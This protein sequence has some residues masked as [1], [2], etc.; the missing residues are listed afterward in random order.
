MP[1]Y[2]SHLVCPVSS[3]PVPYGIVETDPQGTI[4]KI[5]ETGGRLREEAGLEFYPGLLVPGFVNAHCHLELSHLQTHIP[6]GSGLVPFIK[7]ISSDR[8]SAE[9]VILAAAAQADRVMFLSGISGVGDISNTR[10]TLGI[11][12]KS[13]ML[14][15]TFAEV[16]GLSPAVA[17]ERFRLGREIAVR[18]RQEGLPATLSPHAPYSL[19]SSLWD[20]ISADPEMAT[21][22]SIHHD[23]SLD[24]RELLEYG[25]GPMAD[26]FREMG[27][28]P[29][30]IPAEASS[31]TR[32]LDAYLP[33]AVCLAVH[34]TISPREK[35]HEIAL[36]GGSSAGQ[37][38]PAI[39]PVLC[40]LSNLYL[41]NT[42]PDIK[43]M[44]ELGMPVCLGTDSLASNPGLSILEEMKAIATRYPEIPFS[45]LLEWATLN[46][47]RALGFQQQLGS[48]EPG[49][50]PGVIHIS[51]YDW[52]SGGLRLDSRA[53]RLI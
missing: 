12:K 9:G 43:A 17:A 40:P 44:A 42:L 25:N 20:L 35:L 38:T 10:I 52:E 11:K 4:L 28:D 33:R 46:G 3:P 18:F 23:E 31:L 36:R 26:A 1:K 22:I 49:K 41:T 29:S 7:T 48:L 51:G 32:L 13:P 27:L 24:E 53:T 5:R 8:H 2:A 34:N 14:Y 37:A 6:P 45:L 39:I 19:S 30:G 47:A 15:H 21:L 50:R 16:M